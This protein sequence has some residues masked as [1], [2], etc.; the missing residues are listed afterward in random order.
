MPRKKKKKPK[1]SPE[2]QKKLK[3][4]RAH[5]NDARSIFK[6]VGFKRVPGAAKTEITYQGTTSDLDDLF[7]FEN[8][9]VL[10]EYT[11]KQDDLSGHLKKKKVLYD[12]IQ[13]DASS[14]IEFLDQKIVNFTT[15]RNSLFQPA[16]MR[17]A[18][19]YCSLK[20]IE[21]DL[22]AE[23]PGVRYLDY[24]YLKY[25][26]AL[27]RAIKLSAR[28]ELFHFLGFEH[29]DVGKNVISS[30]AASE[31]YEGSIL[32]EAHS[33]F[34][35]DHKIVSFYVDPGAL[36]NRCYV[37]RKD[38]WEET[39]NLYQRMISKKKLESIRKYLIEQKRVFV[40]NIIITLPE[41]THLRAIHCEGCSKSS[42]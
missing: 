10:V 28:F 1:L 35:K 12:K 17:V 13:K 24:Q 18:I 22:K 26:L 31:S 11:T 15:A 3:A 27:A 41:D 14:F 33:N 37:L 9:V 16:Q 36:L 2:E 20:K 23:V 29:A 42:Q 7:V 39:S 32:P 6:L 5:I 19:V 25:F 21:A 34:G 30:S 8:L 40:N 38:R 4:Q